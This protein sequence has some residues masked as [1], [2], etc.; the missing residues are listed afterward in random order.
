MICSSKS[1]M[2]TDF[3]Q[4]LDGPSLPELLEEK[5]ITWKAYLENYPGNGFKAD[6]SDDK[7]YVRKH[8]PFI[9]M[10]NI[11]NNPTMVSK[12]VNSKQ[13]ADDIEKDDVPQYVFYVPNINNNGEKTN[14]KFASNFLKNEFIP[15]I[16]HLLTSSRTLL[17]ITFDEAST[18]IDFN[19][20]NYNQ[21]Y[22]TLI[23]PN[24]LN[25]VTHNDGTR[26]SHFSWV[27]TIEENWNLS[28]LGNGVDNDRVSTVPLDS[29]LF[30]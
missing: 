13:L 10:N 22:T 17:V 5:S 2:L 6:A 25:S 26:Y 28:R 3:S 18:Y 16:Q 21:I 27:P 9:S 4:N 29:K 7:L 30:L 19:L 8:N 15:L 12:I 11:R 1:G 24:V 14:L 20:A 23:G